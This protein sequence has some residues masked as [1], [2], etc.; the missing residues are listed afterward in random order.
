MPAFRRG[1]SGNVDNVSEP[2]SSWAAGAALGR[3]I[4]RGA[5]VAVAYLSTSLVVVGVIFLLGR[6]GDA[7]LL[8]E[9]LAIHFIAALAAGLEPATAKAAALRATER[10][11]DEAVVIDA[12]AGA[13]VAI[14]A[15][16][17]LLAWPLLAIVWRIADPTLDPWLLAW[18]WPV[19]AAGFT[20]TDLRVLLD[21][22]GRHAAAI[23]LKQGSLGG[24]LLV[25][26]ALAWGGASLPVALGVATFGR[27]A[28]VAFAIKRNRGSDGYRLGGG[29]LEH[30]KDVRWLELAGASVIAAIG[31]SADRVFG[32]RFLAPEA[33]AAY[34]LLYEVFSKFWFIPYILGPIVFAK[35][36]RGKDARAT[37]R[38]A[39]RFT[40]LAGATFVVVVASVA[41]LVP[42]A[43]TRL[44]GSK[45][46]AIAPAGTIVAF[47]AAVA[48]NSLVQ[49]RV[50]ELQGEGRARRTL[51]VMAVSA[52]IATMLFWVS[53]RGWGAPGLLVAWLIK[54]VFELGAVYFPH[55]RSASSRTVAAH[56]SRAKEG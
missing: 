28:I 18:L 7:R 3:T 17:A 33:W 48:I 55:G 12:S 8:R 26:A 1:G 38:A 51:V 46:G 9:I 49:L 42:D 6:F 4:A 34:Y 52:A 15:I 27:L 45:L 43:P 13:I 31:G 16:K 2:G 44:M 47:A 32:L 56:H 40:A 25:M 21:L 29:V 5:T 50:A 10:G 24:G 22:R 37:A 35:V 23:W 20:A 30:L 39:W 53:A 19:C 36:A 11:P 14:G 54:S 41:I